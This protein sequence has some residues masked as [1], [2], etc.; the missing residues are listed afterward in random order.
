MATP[1]IRQFKTN[2]AASG[3]SIAATFDL[4]PVANALILVFVGVSHVAQTTDPGT[5]SVS[6]NK[7][8]TYNNKVTQ[9][10]SS[11]LRSTVE[12][13]TA[14]TATAT[15]TVTAS[16][17]NNLP[18]SITIVELNGH[19]AGQLQRSG[20]TFGY[21]DGAAFPLSPLNFA[22]TTSDEQ[23][24][25]GMLF[26]GAGYSRNYGADSGWTQLDE[27]ASSTTVPNFCLIYKDVATAGVCDPSW[28]MAA[29]GATIQVYTGLTIL[30]G[31]DGAGSS[32]KPAFYYAQL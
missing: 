17:T 24:A 4:T 31:N 16:W 19:D 26:S 8:N 18:C 2:S 23:L 32:A 15:F 14:A 27:Q 9:T 25:M 10:Y 28:T 12:G 13:A 5:I 29:A 20:S 6:D 22:N 30:P 7:G 21:N 11:G 3:T 1:T